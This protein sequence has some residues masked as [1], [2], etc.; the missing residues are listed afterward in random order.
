M[1]CSKCE[2]ALPVDGDYVLCVLCDKGFHYDCSVREARWRKMSA[3]LKSKWSCS[4]C[5]DAPSVARANN[6]SP[7]L[8]ETYNACEE[9]VSTKTLLH[10]MN[11]RLDTLD[12]VK[13]S[14]DSM[15][16]SLA[17]LSDKYDVLL[18][19]VRDYKV[20]NDELKKS[21]SKLKLECAEKDEALVDLTSRFNALEQYGR[22]INLEIH[23]LEQEFRD[24]SMEV[25]LKK[26][27]TAI[28]QPFNTW[29]IQAAHRIP[30]KSERPS[31]LLVQFV[32]KATKLRWLIAGRKRR[33]N[34][35][36]IVG[37]GN[38]RVYFNENLT[39]YY[40]KLFQETR[41][42]A[43]EKGYESV[44]LLNGTIRVK[45]NRDDRSRTII[46]ANYDDLKR[47]A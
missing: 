27:A 15:S 25:V 29:E 42:V 18:K 22:G 41:R 40:S 32:S 20:A 14:V 37:V 30:T 36:D 11:S 39:P 17:F 38:Q 9:E 44:W 34:S 35:K 1:K 12:E 24:E 2:V 45:K 4:D 21:V 8:S 43:K 16:T 13:K 3:D 31:T 10:R 46:I 19:E 5:K 28:G 33:L 6:A 23:G 26:V 47:V 7:S